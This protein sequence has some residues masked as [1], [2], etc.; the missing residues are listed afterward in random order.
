M[1]VVQ[2]RC[3]LYGLL[4]YPQRDRAGFFFSYGFYRN[5]VMLLPEAHRD[6]NEPKVL[7]L[8]YVDVLH[9]TDEAVPGVEDAPLAQFALGGRGCWVNASR[10]RFMGFSLPLGGK[11]AL[12]TALDYSAVRSHQAVRAAGSPLPRER[13]AGPIARMPIV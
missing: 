11:G 1:R 12:L 9:M 8:I 7:L 4:I 13:N 6:I 10:V 2:R 3:A 5:K